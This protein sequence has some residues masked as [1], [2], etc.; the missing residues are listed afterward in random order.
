[1]VF[2]IIPNKYFEHII[3]GKE[4]HIKLDRKNIYTKSIM[5]IFEVPIF[6]IFDI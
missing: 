6:R 2:R 1:M 5:D 3:E 4:T